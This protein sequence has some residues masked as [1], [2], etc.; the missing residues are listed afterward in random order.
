MWLK[1][2]FPS[3]SSYI[4]IAQPSDMLVAT[5]KQYREH[6]SQKVPLNGAIW[7]IIPDVFTNFY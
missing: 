1:S 2:Q 5:V 7:R 4:L 3:H 6:L